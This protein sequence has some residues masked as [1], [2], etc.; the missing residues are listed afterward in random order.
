MY[1]CELS[2]SGISHVHECDGGGRKNGMRNRETLRPKLEEY[3]CL[4]YR[5]NAKQIL[6]EL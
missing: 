6:K 3:S 2:V 5:S 1:I 4:L